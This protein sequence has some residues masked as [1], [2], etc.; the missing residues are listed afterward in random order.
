VQFPIFVANEEDAAADASVFNAAR[1]MS[2]TLIRRTDPRRH[3]DPLARDL[4]VGDLALP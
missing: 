4:R 1:H 2:G 3:W